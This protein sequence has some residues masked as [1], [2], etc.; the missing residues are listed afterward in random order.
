MPRRL[1]AEGTIFRAAPALGVLQDV[2]AYLAAVMSFAHLE[3]CVEQ[4]QELAIGGAQDGPR[5]VGRD[6]IALEGDV[7]QLAPAAHGT[8]IGKGGEN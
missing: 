8:L 7:G 1:A 4:G 2:K 5:V 6:G 3:G